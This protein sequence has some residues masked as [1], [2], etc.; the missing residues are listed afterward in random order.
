[1]NC[2]VTL[3]AALLM[4]FACRLAVADQPAHPGFA[5]LP[6]AEKVVDRWKIAFAVSVPTDVEVA[7]LNPADDVIR[8]LA[9]GAVGGE[10]VP[11]SPLKAALTQ[12]LFWDGAD[13][14]GRQVSTAGCKICVRLGMKA[15]L[16][17]MLMNQR[18]LAFAPRAATVGPD[19]LVYVL[20][21]QGQVKSTFLLEAYTQDGKYVK[22]VMPYSA[23]LPQERLRGLPHLKM[24]DGRFL[25]II[26]HAG[27]RDLYP[28]S[29]GMRPQRMLITSKGWIVLVNSSR[30][31]NSGVRLA[32]RLLVID[33]D[34]GTPTANYLGPRTSVEPC[35]YGLC[36]LALSPDERWIYTS[37]HLRD[38]RYDDGFNTPP[39]Q[40]VYRVGWEDPGQAQPFLGRLFQAGSDPS[41]FNDPRGI[42]VDAQGRIYIC[43]YGNNRVAA[44]DR[45][46]RWIGKIDVQ[47]PDQVAVHKTTGA[48]Y[49]LSWRPERDRK[50]SVQKL[51]KFSGIDAA[52]MATRDVGPPYCT[53]SLDGSGKPANLWLARTFWETPEVRRG[54]EK[55]QDLGDAFSVPVGIIKHRALPDVYHLGAS[56]VNDDVFAHSYSE[57]QFARIDGQIGEVTLLPGVRGEDVAVGPQGQILTLRMTSFSPGRKNVEQY[58]RD[59]VPLRFTS[60]DGNAIRAVPGN[61]YGHCATA[62]RGF[63]VSPRGEIAVM[64]QDETGRGVSIYSPDG[65]LKVRRIVDGLADCDGSPVMDLAG[66]VYVA[67]AAKPRT[68]IL[69]APFDAARPPNPYYA[70]MYGSVI[71]FSARGGRLYYKPWEAKSGQWPPAG[72]DAMMP[73]VSNFA[74]VEAVADGA[75]WSRGGF[76]VVPASNGAVSCCGCYTSRFGVDGYGRVFIPDVGQFSVVV[77]DAHNNFLLRF[78]DYGN[79]DSAGPGSPVPRPEIPLSWPFAVSVGR[80]GVYVSDFINRRIVRVDLHFAA[81]E[82]CELK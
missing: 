69:P 21:E 31:H 22:T 18:G 3:R 23:G 45:N 38:G 78:G 37:G 65:K 67:A 60:L 50:K 52:A 17:R 64:D 57:H 16:G 13:D 56:M 74:G 76:T 20:S 11:P 30:T 35:P 55:V 68:E 26:G 39:H 66:N 47:S 32:Q 15:R 44:F 25:P 10:R 51:Q 5:L 77:V 73:L 63:C 24:P 1:M 7:V 8:H 70:W 6:K 59:G 43:D 53:M 41:H 48:I 54:V 82:C 4:A 36:W 81:T 34:G 75:L 9:A 2:K 46:G 19:G 49:V 14:F 61:I 80:G 28:E 79:A 62:S 29:T 72:A 12:E 33:T 58:D 42:D 27:F 71:K 40:V